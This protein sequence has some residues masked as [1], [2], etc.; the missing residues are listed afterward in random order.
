MLEGGALRVGLRRIRQVVAVAV[1]ADL[2]AGVA[3]GA[4]LGRVVLGHPAGYIEGR[5]D[6]L[7]AEEAEEPRNADPRAVAALRHDP[8][9]VGGPRIAREPERLGVEVERQHDGAAR[10]LR[11]RRRRSGHERSLRGSLRMIL[12][13]ASRVPHPRR[14]DPPRCRP[15]QA[16]RRASFGSL[17]PLLD[18]RLGSVCWTHASLLTYAFLTP[19][20]RF[21]QARG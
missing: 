6:A 12:Q 9:E 7:G 3:D 2:V 21:P 17:N 14:A 4:R 1:V 11:P 15:R 16:S 10:A 8:R 13:R 5:A 18:G 19:P 20:R